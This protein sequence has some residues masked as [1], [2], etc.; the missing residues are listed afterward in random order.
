MA[1]APC[2]GDGD[3]GAAPLAGPDRAVLGVAE[4]TAVPPGAPGSA[5]G[6]KGRWLLPV[7]P[8]MGR[9]GDAARSLHPTGM[10]GLFLCCSG[11]CWPRD[12]GRSCP[13]CPESPGKGFGSEGGPGRRNAARGSAHSTDHRCHSFP[14]TTEPFCSP[15]TLRVRF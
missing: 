6:V 3:S 5:G 13:G 8:Q 9:G 10:L 1:A 15:C 4:G 14:S 11:L 2:P 12:S 7:V